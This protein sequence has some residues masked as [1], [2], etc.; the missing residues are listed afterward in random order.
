MPTMKVC[1][2]QALKTYKDEKRIIDEKKDKGV[3]VSISEQSRPWIKFYS[4]IEKAILECDRDADYY[5]VGTAYIEYQKA[6]VEYHKNT[7][8]DIGAAYILFTKKKNLIKAV[9]DLNLSNRAIRI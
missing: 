1:A 5:A 4:T 6:R 3:V 9:A 2:S 8:R 7:G